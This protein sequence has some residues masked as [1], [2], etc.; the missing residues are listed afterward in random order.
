MT[1]PPTEIGNIGGVTAFYEPP[2]NELVR[3]EGRNKES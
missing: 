2:Q 3:K 1:N